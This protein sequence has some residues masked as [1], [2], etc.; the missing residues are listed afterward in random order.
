MRFN[1]LKGLIGSALL[2]SLNVNARVLQTSNYSC[3]HFISIYE[4]CKENSYGFVSELVIKENAYIESGV[5]SSFI[6][7]EKLV[8]SGSQKYIQQYHFNEISS[9]TSLRELHLTSASFSSIQFDMSVFRKNTAL[10]Y[11]ELSGFN[12]ESCRSM[13]FKGLQNIQTLDVSK[14]SLSQNNIIEISKLEKL[15][16]MMIQ[17]N[18]SFSKLDISALKRMRCLKSLSISYE[19]RKS[20]H[21][22]SFAS[23]FEGFSYLTELQLN[24]IKLSHADITAISNLTR[25]T[26]I[27]MINCDFSNSG[28][29]SLNRL[30]SLRY[31][32]ITKAHNIK[33]QT[34][35][36]KSL[37]KSEYQVSRG[38]L[39]I[40]KKMSALSSSTLNKYSYCK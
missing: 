37:I 40:A 17:I 22:Q 28:I 8:I 29:S 2:Y 39:C 3:H 18:D 27:S 12:S 14:F 19:E 35:V 36:N 24:S 25:L 20:L 5:I 7:L 9:L 26:N 34:L 16:K 32:K 10:S 30:D 33:A 38:E 21:Y 23:S 15:N 11:L 6:G 31:F 13:S 4:S 1:F